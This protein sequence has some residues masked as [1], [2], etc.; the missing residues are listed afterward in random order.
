MFQG[1]SLYSGV[2]YAQV[3]DVS[4]GYFSKFLEMHTQ[5][6]DIHTLDIGTFVPYAQISYVY[7][8]YLFQLPY[9]HT[10]DIGTFVPY[11][12]TSDD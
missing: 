2:I 6:P 8:G 12:Q 4:Q 11:A 3:D 10:L 1:W 5:L 7:L 9:V